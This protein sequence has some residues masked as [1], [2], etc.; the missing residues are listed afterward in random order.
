L[1]VF[2]QLRDVLAAENSSVV[3]EKN[4]YRRLR[5]PQRTETKLLSLAIGKDDL[6]E[7]AA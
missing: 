2:A 1:L 3:P 4:Q 5:G 6:R 7:L